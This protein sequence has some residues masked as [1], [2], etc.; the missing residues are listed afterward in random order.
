MRYPVV[1]KDPFSD[2]MTYNP[3]QVESLE[4]FSYL[5]C[6]ECPFDCKEDALFKVHALE[7]HPMSIVLFGVRSNCEDFKVKEELPDTSLVDEK[8]QDTNDYGYIKTEPI[9]EDHPQNYD[10]ENPNSCKICK[11]SFFKGAP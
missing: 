4:A 3:W 11:I 1:N 2:T 6:P 7:N 5:K 10:I 8:G 9:S